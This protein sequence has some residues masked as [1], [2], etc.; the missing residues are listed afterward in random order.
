MTELKRKYAIEF[1][2]KFGKKPTQKELSHYIL[3]G[4]GNREEYQKASELR[5]TKWHYMN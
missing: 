4:G 2:L 5:R 1:R 3:I